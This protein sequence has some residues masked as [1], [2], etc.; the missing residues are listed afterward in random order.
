VA[1][2]PGGAIFSSRRKEK[3]A[4]P[5]SRS[6]KTKKRTYTPPPAAK[7]KQPSPVWWAPVMVGLMV[8]GLVW[9]VV[10]YLSEGRFPIG[11]I[12]NWNLLIG[13]GLMLT[14]FGLTTGWK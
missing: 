14:G 11:A 8:L 3:T 9:V 5:E 12:G 7:A 13:F 6:R 2:R 1:A 4:V 10:F